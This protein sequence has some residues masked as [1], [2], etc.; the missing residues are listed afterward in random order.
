VEKRT[1][2][3]WCRVKLI[4]LN[5]NFRISG[6]KKKRC[7][8]P[9]L[10]KTC[11]IIKI[12]ITL[13]SACQMSLALMV[14]EITANDKVALIKKNLFYRVGNAPLYLLF[15]FHGILIH[16]NFFKNRA[17]GSYDSL[18]SMAAMG[19]SNQTGKHFYSDQGVQNKRERYYQC[20]RL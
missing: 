12:S 6:V 8:T 16:P 19:Y 11:S 5:R 2:R 9:P 7:A 13:E 4:C 3:Q 18:I 10:N 14:C 1:E 15:T 20:H 17:I